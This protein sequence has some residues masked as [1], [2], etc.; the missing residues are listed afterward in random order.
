MV[1]QDHVRGPPLRQVLLVSVPITEAVL[2]HNVRCGGH[3]DRGVSDDAQGTPRRPDPRMIPTVGAGGNG[4]PRYGGAHRGLRAAAETLFGGVRGLR[5]TPI[6]NGGEVWRAVNR[7]V[8][9]AWPLSRGG[10]LSRSWAL[11]IIGKPS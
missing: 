7:C 1:R 8:V 11:V 3:I 10:S 9:F 2:C 5:S 6:R 4:R